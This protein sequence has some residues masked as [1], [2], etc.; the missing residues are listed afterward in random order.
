[1]WK[2]TVLWLSN[3][4]KYVF[5][6]VICFHNFSLHFLCLI[7]WSFVFSVSNFDEVRNNVLND[8]TNIFNLRQGKLNNTIQTTQSNI[9]STWCPQVTVNIPPET[10][11]DVRNYTSRSIVYCRR[12]ISQD[13]WNCF[14]DST[15]KF[16]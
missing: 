10:Q 12:G 2:E 11:S 7:W 1:M 16:G 6:I 15:I 4:F 8:E 5:H 9:K 14:I 13:R 3:K